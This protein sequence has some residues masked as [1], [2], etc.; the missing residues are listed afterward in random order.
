MGSGTI[1]LVNKI[2]VCKNQTVKMEMASLTI[3]LKPHVRNLCS[4]SP[5]ASLSAPEGFDSH[6]CISRFHIFVSY[7][8]WQKV[9]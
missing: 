6:I 9:K 8:G 5:N 4:L 1:T 7:T 2:Y 3:S